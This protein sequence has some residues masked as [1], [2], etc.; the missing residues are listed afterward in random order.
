MRLL[1][2]AK[3]VRGSVLD[4]F[5]WAEV[6]RVERRL[7]GEYWTAIEAALT[8]LDAAAIPAA[9]ELADLAEVV[10]GYEDIKLANV[11][12]FRAALSEATKQMSDR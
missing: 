11:E 1:A 7:A 6:R 4:P 10:R 5:R 2:R 9:V 3:A 8:G 12:R